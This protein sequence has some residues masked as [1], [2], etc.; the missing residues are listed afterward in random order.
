MSVGVN[1]LKSTPLIDE[2]VR[3]LREKAIALE[4]AFEFKAARAIYQEI[5]SHFKSSKIADQARRRLT[6]MDDLIKEKQSYER[7][8][9]NG[10]RVLTDIGIDMAT[11]QP[12]MDILMEADAIDFDSDTAQF[13]PFKADYIARCLEQVPRQMAGD[14][15]P[16]AFGTGATPPFLKRPDNDDL[17]AANRDEFREIVRQAGNN[18]D[19][20]K[21]FSLPVATDKSISDFEA[22]KLM[23]TGFTGLKMTATRNMADNEAAF[24]KGKADWLD[25]TSL[26]TSLGIMQTMV[27]PFLRSARIGNNLLLL[28]LTIAGVS[29][30][31]SPEALLTQ[32]HAQVMFMMILAQTVTPGIECIHGGIPDVVGP[33]GDLSYSSPSQPL[34]NAAMARLNRWVTGFPSAQSGGSTSITDVTPEA[35]AESDQSRRTL[36]KYGV[37]ILRH[38]MGALGSLNFFSLEKFIEDCRFERIAEQKDQKNGNARGIIPLY[39]PS[40]D[41]AF[42]GIREIAEKGNPKNADHTLKNVDALIKWEKVITEAALKRERFPELDENVSGFDSAIF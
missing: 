39:L 14:P 29:G 40:D 41:T 33:D 36:R 22:A 27:D 9:Q 28:D 17:R 7:I 32:V 21:I 5:A 24:L 10:L 38:A 42:S 23:E 25:G 18:E 30:P 11:S 13:I 1:E 6:D 19:V 3:A 16:N 2:N 8:H 34:L 4:T 26:A 12:L 20:V 35:I 31:I 15:G 37:H